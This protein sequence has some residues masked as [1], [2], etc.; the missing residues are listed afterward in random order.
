[1]T[2]AHY[3]V[4]LSCAAAMHSLSATQRVHHRMTTHLSLSD[5]DTVA[6][7][8]LTHAYA[9]CGD[10]ATAVGVF[11]AGVARGLQFDT[12]GWNVLIAAYA[13]HG[14][15]DEARHTLDRM[16]AAG[17]PPD[18]VTMTSLLSAASHSGLGIG[19]RHLFNQLTARYPHIPLNKIHSNCVIDGLARAGLVDDAVTEAT[20]AGVRDG[21]FA[22]TSV[23]GGAHTHNRLDIAELAF[24]HIRRLDPANQDGVLAA[25][26]V[27]LAHMYTKHGHHDKAAAL[28][29]GMKD[30]RISKI[31]GE[32]S[33]EVDGVMHTFRVGDTSHPEMAAIIR[34]NDELHLR[35]RGHGYEPDTVWV[36]RDGS[37]SDEGKAQLLC[38]HSERLALVYGLL[39]SPTTATAADGG[40]G[41]D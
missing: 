29:T 22:W 31:P 6:I 30:G 4:L 16:T 14:M 18:E 3:T 41:R 38:E 15:L 33:I 17:V 12:T 37:M 26:H 40:G 8:A 21:M 24:N 7:G 36:D 23:L 5:I 28:R 1:M 9:Q 19:V 10:L 27:T 13:E 34:L 20:A 35:L 32:S 25:A 39:H 2:P 11:E